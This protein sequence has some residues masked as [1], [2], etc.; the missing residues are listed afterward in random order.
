MT[1]DGRTM[2]VVCGGL[3]NSL[4]ASRRTWRILHDRPVLWPVPASPSEAGALRIFATP[5][6]LYRRNS[7]SRGSRPARGHAVASSRSCLA[8]PRGGRLLR[9]QI[10]VREHHRGP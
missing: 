8:D 2:T 4:A 3:E 6:F 1:V 7:L 5:G 9:H 10:R